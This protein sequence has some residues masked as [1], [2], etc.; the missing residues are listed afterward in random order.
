MSWSRLSTSGQTFNNACPLPSLLWVN[1]EA[2]F[3]AMRLQN[4]TVRDE[5]LRQLLPCQAKGFDYIVDYE[6]DTFVFRNMLGFL[7]YHSALQFYGS[8]GS[9]SPVKADLRRIA[10]LKIDSLDP[11]PD[12]FC[13]QIEEYLR[14]LLPIFTSLKGVCFALHLQF[15]D[16]SWAGLNLEPAR[17]IGAQYL[18]EYEAQQGVVGVSWRPPTLDLRIVEVP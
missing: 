5:A 18:A 15:G 11:T 16:A 2:R 3:V 4:Y 17:I 12:W 6:L 14:L 8:G 1:R 13:S 10:H 9:F 7:R